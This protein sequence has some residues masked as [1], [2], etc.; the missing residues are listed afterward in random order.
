MHQLGDPVILDDMLLY[1]LW[2]YQAR[3]GSLVTRMCEAEFGVTRREWRLL[4]H[5]ALG[6]GIV[7][8]QLAERTGLDR[9]RTSRALTTLTQKKLVRRTPRPGDHRQ[10]LVDL[11]DEGRRLYGALLPRVA[12]INRA[13]LAALTPAETALLDG[14][15]VRLQAQADRLAGGRP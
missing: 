8:S 4:A 6:D 15:L 14:L 11:T 2:Q 5:L 12:D 1:V 7:S 3:A 10:V 9:A 13:L